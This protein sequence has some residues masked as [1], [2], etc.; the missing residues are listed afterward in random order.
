VI[1]YIRMSES[2]WKELPRHTKIK[3]LAEIIAI[4]G[5]LLLVW[6]NFDQLHLLREQL[7]L[8]NNTL[9]L[10]NDQ[11]ELNQKQLEATQKQLKLFGEQIGMER[12]KSEAQLECRM[13]RNFY[14]SIHERIVMR[15]S[16]SLS[17]EDKI[18]KTIEE[19]IA[20]NKAVEQASD[21]RMEVV[22]MCRNRSTRATAIEDVIVKDG[23]GMDLDG[24]DY[25][26]RIHLPIHVEAW[27]L[28]ETIFEAQKNDIN[29]I[30]SIL[31]RDMDD[32]EYLLSPGSKWVKGKKPST[33]PR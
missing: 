27:G 31:I 32:N 20:K 9:K 19:K 28:K 16:V 7:T 14:V 15:D 11:L 22:L 18:V 17:N 5:G 4:A 6:L 1:Y 30:K 29:N 33:A 8:N 2:S 3:Y 25:H 21:D 13:W 26:N 23:K 10:G 12:A 24:R